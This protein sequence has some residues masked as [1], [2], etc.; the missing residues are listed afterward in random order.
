M[1]KADH[2]GRSGAER[3]RMA[4][5]LAVAVVGVAPWLM[6]G[7]ARAQETSTGQTAGSPSLSL[8][9]I[10]AELRDPKLGT[11]PRYE[12]ARR[13]LSEY[14]QSGTDAAATL[15]APGAEPLPQ[16]ALIHA[17]IVRPEPVPAQ[18]GRP[19][20][21]LLG[22][23][24]PVVDAD[25][26]VAIGRVS[27]RDVLKILTDT[28]VDQGATPAR[29][30]SA[31]LA[32]GYQRRKRAAEA[33]VAVLDS[34]NGDDRAAATRALRSLT[35][36]DSLGDNPQRWRE[37]W[38]QTRQLK[39]EAWNAMVS[40]RLALRTDELAAANQVVEDRLVQML[41]RVYLEAAPEQR[42]AMLLKMLEDPLLAVRRQ[43]LELAGRRLLDQGSDRVE[44][45]LRAALVARIDDPSVEIQR[46]AVLLLR[47]LAEPTAADAVAARLNAAGQRPEEITQ[48][49]ILM[50]ARQPR[51]QCLD[52]LIDLLGNGRLYNDAAVALIRAADQ[53]LLTPSQSRRAAQGIHQY[54]SLR[55]QP[56]EPVMVE[57]LG[58]VADA[59]D[60]RLIEQWLRHPVP[61]VAEAAA[62][63]WAESS[64]PLDAALRQTYEPGVQSILFAAT[65]RRSSQTSTFQAL[66]AARPRDAE[67]AKA[68]AE[69][70][71][72]S[73]QHVEGEVVLNA[74][75]QLSD[76]AD[77]ALRA[78]MLGAALEPLLANMKPANGTA[79][80]TRPVVPKPAVVAELLLAR[81]EL[82]LAMEQQRDALA[83]LQ[84][85][86]T[87]VA[88][89]PQETLRRRDDLMLHAL[90]GI[91]DL[92]AA[93]DIATASLA[94]AVPG[95][96]RAARLLQLA[97]SF[98]D[99]AE[100]QT[101]QRKFDAARQT[102]ARL[103]EVLP[104]PLPPQITRRLAEL[105]SAMPSAPPAPAGDQ[106]VAD[107]SMHDPDASPVAPKAT[108]SPGK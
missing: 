1:R 2:V 108:A 44:P 13:L 46:R 26:A 39:E 104:A 80:A 29:R 74:A 61:E 4:A 64:Q 107:G 105:Q 11:V 33:L 73:C 63:A 98:L 90:L 51:P 86:E 102:L 99:C 30:R 7:Q 22:R 40:D 3:R 62:R 103:A 71:V 36:I 38:G 41:G 66:L 75:A 65:G 6:A 60:W 70:L 27:D 59:R 49:Y 18:L 14:G 15:L 45:D 34:P 23:V 78:Q 76:P 47:D 21:A 57:L 72:K 89:L 77:R 9:Q 50:L 68:W 8:A 43:A 88:D 106:P 95:P 58:R 82:R 32:L 37:W 52:R 54:L 53:Q 94:R 81:A 24:D 87:V 101:E 96:P 85:L 5:L 69:A 100:R 84:W 83:D 25:L 12:L 93:G 35:G 20:V 16:Q 67:A 28:A 79:A 10:V 92:T 31:I 55:Q 91:E 19:L 17:L 97:S 56:P 42:L 48:A